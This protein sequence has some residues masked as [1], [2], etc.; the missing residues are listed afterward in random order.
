M[1]VKM[2]ADVGEMDADVGEMDADVGEWM[3]M[4]VKWMRMLVRWMRMLV[5]YFYID[6]S[7][8]EVCLAVLAPNTIRTY[9]VSIKWS[10][11]PCS[12]LMNI[13]RLEAHVPITG[14]YSVKVMG[15]NFR[16]KGRSK[17]TTSRQ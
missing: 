11:F 10:S 16:K 12:T 15:S 3:R 14:G 5:K 7:L 17:Q 4:L 8:K 6:T 1:L 2:D 9:G 13:P